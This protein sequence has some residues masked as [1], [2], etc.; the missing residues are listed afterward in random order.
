MASKFTNFL[1]ELGK[2][3]KLLEDYKN[4]PNSV[5]DKAGLTPA[6]KTLL[7]SGDAKLILAAFYNDPA[8]KNAMGAPLA[9]QFVP[10]TYITIV[11][12]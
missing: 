3:P 7:L 1:V 11:H 10:A 12:P 4:D 8:N 9:Q 5:I 2:N 6:E